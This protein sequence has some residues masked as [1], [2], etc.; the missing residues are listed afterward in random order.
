MVNF[1]FFTL[2][3]LDLSNLNEK[4]KIITQMAIDLLVTTTKSNVLNAQFLTENIE[5]S[6]IKSI[7]LSLNENSNINSTLE[8]F[9]TATLVLIKN[10]LYLAKNEQLF[11]SL[12][13]L[14]FSDPGNIPLSMIMLKVNL[15]FLI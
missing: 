8:E 2:F 12:L 10:L 6:M 14:L 3:F 4:Q 5:M 11:S 15:S 9:K 7:L 1:K 13:Q